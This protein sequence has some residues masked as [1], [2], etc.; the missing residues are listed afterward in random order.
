MLEATYNKTD[1]DDVSGYSGLLTIISNMT[2]DEEAIRIL[3]QV[4]EL[5]FFNNYQ[6]SHYK[7]GQGNKKQSKKLIELDVSNS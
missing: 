7:K 3:N 1:L 2:S 5:A 6:N 4:Q